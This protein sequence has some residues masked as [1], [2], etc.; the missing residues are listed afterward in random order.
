MNDSN[1]QKYSSEIAKTTI[2]FVHLCICPLYL[3]E[4]AQLKGRGQCS[5]LPEWTKEKIFVFIFGEEEKRD[6]LFDLRIEIV[7]LGSACSHVR[8]PP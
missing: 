1:K 5:N 3:V 2:L 4:D 8:V 6:Q 7:T